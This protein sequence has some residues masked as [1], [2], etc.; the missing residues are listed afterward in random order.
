ML[1]NFT[2][3][4]GGLFTSAERP[5]GNEGGGIRKRST[6]VNTVGKG[7]AFLSHIKS[8]KGDSLLKNRKIRKKKPITKKVIRAGKGLRNQAKNKKWEE[9][10]KSVKDHLKEI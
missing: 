8:Y 9:K 5:Q 6:S 2:I 4:G 3:S 7:S 1:I 10:S